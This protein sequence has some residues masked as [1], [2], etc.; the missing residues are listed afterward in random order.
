MDREQG[1]RYA[2]AIWHR[3]KGLYKIAKGISDDG[4]GMR[5]SDKEE[6]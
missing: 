5:N 2:G 6:P 1:R 3:D 4:V